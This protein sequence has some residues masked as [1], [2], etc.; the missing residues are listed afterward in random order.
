M[1]CARDQVDCSSIAETVEIEGLISPDSVER[2]VC[3]RPQTGNGPEALQFEVI[4]SNL[5]T[6]F[7]A[8]KSDRITEDYSVYIFVRWT[9]PGYV[10]TSIRCEPLASTGNGMA[11]AFNSELICN[12]CHVCI[13][14]VSAVQST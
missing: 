2:Q 10:F 7:Q 13:A 12:K 1:I 9:K 6:S 8:Y 11:V 14:G 5:C 4:D 3:V